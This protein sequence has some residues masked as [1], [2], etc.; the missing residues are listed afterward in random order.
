MSEAPTKTCDYCDAVG[1]MPTFR[2]GE[3]TCLNCLR[4][5]PKSLREANQIIHELRKSSVTLQTT[6]E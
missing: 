4:K 2:D 1:K 3:T 5:A 6:Q